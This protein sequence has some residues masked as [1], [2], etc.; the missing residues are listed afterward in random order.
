MREGPIGL[1]P[2]TSIAR[3]MLDGRHAA[4]V[5]RRSEAPGG[6]TNV[7]GIDRRGSRGKRS[8][9]R[10]GRAGKTVGTG[11]DRAIDMETIGACRGAAR[12]GRPE[13][14]IVGP[15]LGKRLLQRE[16]FPRERYC[17]MARWEART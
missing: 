16:K 14:A 4:E 12:M 17:Q 6:T 1:V 8:R 11:M 5:V 7:I 15:R 2:V 3:E 13:I 10:V 9:G